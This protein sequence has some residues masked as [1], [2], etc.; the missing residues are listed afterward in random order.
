M[1]DDGVAHRPRAA[2]RAVPRRIEQLYTPIIRETPHGVLHAIEHQIEQL[3]VG[4]HEIDQLH[5]KI[6][7]LGC[8]G[9]GNHRT[10][11]VQGGDDLG[12]GIDFTQIQVRV[13]GSVL[14][15]LRLDTLSLE[16]RGI[17]QELAR[18][19]RRQRVVLRQ[20]RIWIKIPGLRI[21]VN[22]LGIRFVGCGFPDRLHGFIPYAV[23]IRG[24]RHGQQI[25]V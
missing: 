5:G 6:G 2:V 17:G 19:E 8:S 21:A 22:D 24:K 16:R 13:A 4:V 7:A 9:N 10:A 3:A 1:L 25:E 11:G 12:L 14:H 15:L 20:R 18:V 23:F